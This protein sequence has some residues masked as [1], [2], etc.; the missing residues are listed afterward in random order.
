MQIAGLA[1][2]TKHNIVSPKPEGPN[3]HGK[4][5]TPINLRDPAFSGTLAV[6]AKPIKNIGTVEKVGMNWGV[7]RISEA[8]SHRAV[9]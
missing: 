6:K 2:S 8:F 4:N 5:N 7:K 1:S 3:C 9:P